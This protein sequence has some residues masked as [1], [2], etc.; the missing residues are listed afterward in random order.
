MI[1]KKLEKNGFEITRFKYERHILHMFG[2]RYFLLL[3][4]FPCSI[5]NRLIG[6]RSYVYGIKTYPADFMYKLLKFVYKIEDIFFNSSTSH[7]AFYLVATKILE[8]LS[9]K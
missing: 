9:K 6:R 3:T 1:I 7:I 4:V 8:E 2:Y 5:Y